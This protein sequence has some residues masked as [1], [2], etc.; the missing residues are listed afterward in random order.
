MKKPATRKARFWRGQ[1]PWP[2][3]LLHRFLA[4]ISL[5][6]GIAT[7]IALSA[8]AEA[9]ANIAPPQFT[10]ISVNAESSGIELK[11]ISANGS[12]Y[13]LESSSDLI[14]WSRET[15]VT[16]GTHF[17]DTTEEFFE[18]RFFRLT[19]TSTPKPHNILLIIV[20]DWGID[21]SPIDNPTGSNL[22]LMPNLES[23]AETG[24]RFQNAYALAKCS[25]TRASIMTGRYPFRHG[26]GSPA[27]AVL[28]VSELTLPEALNDCSAYALGSFGKW[29]LGG[30]NSGPRN[31]GGWPTFAGSLGSGVADYYNWQ[32]TILT[33]NEPPQT[34]ATTSYTT[35]DTTNDAIKWIADQEDQPWFCWLAYNAAHSPFHAP[36]ITVAGQTNPNP[37]AR[38]NRDRFE[39]MLWAM[40]AEIGR[41]IDTIDRTNTN[42]ILLG[43]N[44]TPAGVIQPPFDRTHSKG[45]L[46]EGGTHVPM[47]VTGPI[48]S[49]PGSVNEQLVHCVDVFPTILELAGGDP[50]S[51]TTTLDGISL[52]PNL[53]DQ[54]QSNR[55][56]VCEAF[57]RT[58]SSPGRAI[59]NGDYKLIIF[60]DPSRSTDTAALELYYLPSDPN[61]SNNL[62]SRELTDV[63]RIAY[64]QLL[65]INLELGGNFNQ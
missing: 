65:E 60:D 61:E 16:G 64:D 63:Q 5:S 19:L 13:N 55:A 1:E 14:S 6:R 40:D 37:T 24:I 50:K 53:Q 41:L 20:D 18:Q 49:T 25:P 36:P 10:S 7:N 21:S 3:S 27:G 8:P 57:G 56:I 29:H 45:T 31:N 30:G 39:T 51:L 23:L 44:G 26:I 15:T 43:D 47:I 22:P 46:Y 4:V 9:P 62:L 48:V 32:K 2:V 35:T 28:P 33:D 12:S 52:I 11:W 17:I 42:I 59:R 58:E 34:L 54:G 38:N